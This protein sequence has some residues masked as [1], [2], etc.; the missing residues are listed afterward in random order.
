MPLPFSALQ[1]HGFSEAHIALWE[2]EWPGGGLLPLHERAVRD[3]GFLRGS[4]LAVFAPASAGKTFLGELAALRRFEAGRAAVWLVPTRA[5]A[6][7]KTR[8]FAR[9]YAPLGLRVLCATRE[10]PEND[11]PIA[12]G[13][14][15]WLVAVSEKFAAHLTARPGL[16]HRVGLIVADELHT[17]GDRDRGPAFDLLLTK[18]RHTP[19]GP[20]I[21]AL[22]AETA[23]AGALA[24]WLGAEALHF[25]PRPGDVVEGVVDVESGEVRARSYNSGRVLQAPLAEFFTATQ[26]GGEDGPAADTGGIPAPPRFAAGEEDPLQAENLLRLALW[27]AGARGEQALVF[28]PTRRL[29]RLWA[30]E[31]A[32]RSALEPARRALA[33]L[34]RHEPSRGREAL[35]DCLRAGAAFHNADLPAPL[36]RLIEE[37]FHG[38]EIRLLFSTPT[39]SQGVNLAGRNVLQAA[40]MMGED[41]WT[42]APS[43]RSLSPERFR[44]QGGRAS[45]AGIE[46]HPGR[47][48]VLASGAARAGRLMKNLVEARPGAIAPVLAEPGAALAPLALDVVVSGAARAVAE[49]EAVFFD[50]F[51]GREARS[52]GAAAENALR[53]RLAEALARLESARLIKRDAITGRLAAGGLARAVA[54]AGADPE[55]ATRLLGWLRARAAPGAGAGEIPPAPVEALGAIVPCAEMRGFAPPLT[56]AERGAPGLL[57]ELAAR[58]EAAPGPGARWIRESLA[59]EE[60]YT[61]EDRRAAKLALLLD[62][63]IGPEATDAIEARYATLAG[64]VSAAGAQAAWLLRLAASMAEAL[65]RPATLA[66]ALRRLAERLEPGV[67]EEGL[68]LIRLRVEGAGRGVVAALLREGARTPRDL[69]ELPAER[70]RALAPPEVAQ[71][72]L[73]AAR[74]G[75]PDSASVESAAGSAA[76]SARR[77]REDGASSSISSDGASEIES[78]FLEALDGRTGAVES[79]REESMIAPA[80]SEPATAAVSTAARGCAPQSPG[81]PPETDS[82]ACAGREESRNAGGAGDG[83]EVLVIHADSAGTIEWGGRLASLSPLPFRLLLALTR[84]PGRGMNYSE[85]ERAVWEG[86]AIVE[87]QQLSSHKREVLRALAR[88]MGGESARALI[89]TRPGLGMTLNLP[90]ARIRIV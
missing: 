22:S 87:R 7:E 24:G 34:E 36:R 58:L 31:A 14:F 72:L 38:G 19:E 85:L 3:S 21:L 80:D 81:A 59:R 64:S 32:R 49:L 77:R 12:R 13:G 74:A 70:L 61:P 28:C 84:K 15:D 23:S 26:G 73:E 56:P 75:A 48:L 42:R 16:L 76:P 57:D 17:L 47:S 90:S 89:T 66:A 8:L 51:G 44:A 86:R 65:A 30:R 40:A 52:R 11:P 63:W 43:L 50:S 67:G 18:L 68:A 4:N 10:R 29:S 33:S 54:G 69:L 53:E 62:D 25:D 78:V 6:E 71:A 39:L 35:R 1:S 55:T 82:P 46:S 83:E 9:R 5:L 2:R 37:G 79:V 41:P 45:R 20:Q 60:G 27:I 88:L